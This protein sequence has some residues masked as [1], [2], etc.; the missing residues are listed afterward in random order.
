MNFA[1]LKKLALGLILLVILFIRLDSYHLTEASDAIIEH[2][3]S[4]VRWELKNLPQKWIHILIDSLSG[5][6]L[7]KEDQVKQVYE[8]L[9]VAHI[10]ENEKT[11]L[12]NTPLTRSGNISLIHENQ[13]VSEKYIADLS[14]IKE[15]LRPQVEEFIESQLSL[16]LIEEGLGYKSRIILPPVD[17]KLEQPP[18]VLIISPRNNIQIIESILLN[19]DLSDIDKDEIENIILRESNLSAIVSNLA[20]LATYPSLVS[21]QDTLRAILQTAAHEWIHNYLIFK[22]LGQNFR[23]SSEMYT[24]NETIADLVGREL[25]DSTFA[26]IGG[27]LD[28]SSNKYKS[29]ENRYPVF[30]EQ[31]RE[32]RLKVDQL[33]NDGEIDEAEEYMKKR[34]WLLRLGGYKLRKLNQAYFAFHGMYG[35]GHASISPLGNQVKEFRK[36]FPEVGK[37]IEA[38]SMISSHEEFL[39]ILENSSKE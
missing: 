11:R 29:G 19:P 3:F 25:G 26:R 6:E 13:L 9:R 7:S 17:I 33:L 21:D 18:N 32:T 30:T 37:F 39:K 24:L 38:A 27:D 16:T 8:F 20:G 10:L 12:K 5:K 22:P 28:I 23:T 34:W 2:R 35:E 1:I 4:L 31:M 14:D 36:R 15:K